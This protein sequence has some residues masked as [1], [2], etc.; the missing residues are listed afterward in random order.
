MNSLLSKAIQQLLDDLAKKDSE[1][2]ADTKKRDFELSEDEQKNRFVFLVKKAQ[3]V[4]A[5]AKNKKDI[6]YQAKK[7]FAILVR[8][9]KERSEVVGEEVRKKESDEE[10]DKIM[11]MSDNDARFMGKKDHDV[12]PTYKSHV[13]MTNKGFITY[14][15]VTRS[16]IYDGHHAYTIIWDL[17]SRG[18]NVPFGVGDNH[19]G[20]ITL[21]E[22]MDLQGTQ[23]IAPYRKSQAMNSCLTNDIM[24]EAWGYNHTLEYKEHMRVRAH[25]EPKQGEMKNIHGMKRARFRG[26]ERVRV[27]NYM[28]AIVTNCK[29]LV[30]S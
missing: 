24:I 28:S 26:L 17:K 18:F 2:E 14:T 25:I 30:A 5:F 12:A 21:R 22:D 8:I 1:M 15:D 3:Q 4:L 23:M 19:Y 29:L 27:Q 16:T 20:D 11:S 13:A 10:K 9:V 7:S 6:S